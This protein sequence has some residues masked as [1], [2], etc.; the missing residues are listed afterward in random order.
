MSQI[1]AMLCDLQV[2]LVILHQE[3]MHSTS[4]DLAKAR[5]HR[6]KQGLES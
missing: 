3:E 6:I 4:M 2:Q 1:L 5:N